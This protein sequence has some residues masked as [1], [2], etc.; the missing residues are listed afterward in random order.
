[1][2][3]YKLEF[4]LEHV[5][6][7]ID[8]SKNELSKLT[9][10][11]LN[12]DGMSG[13]KTRHLYNNL[14]SLDNANYLEIGTYK[15]SSFISSLY[16]NNIKSIAIDN[17]SEFN[18]PKLEFLNNIKRYSPDSEYHFIENDCFKISENDIKSIYESVDIY[19]YDG[20][21]DYESQKKAITYYYEYLSRYSI[22]IID[23]FRSDTE[24]WSNVKKGTF[25]GIKESGLKI[26]LHREI[27]SK[28]EDNG[29]RDYWNGCGIF[30]CEKI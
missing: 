19:L 24:N 14:C 20:S 9:P 2:N 7:S 16:K 11:I 30:V 17:W 18:G 23:D 6:K 15:G 10:E 4:L 29:R 21:H 3:K 27:D 12:M 8:N 28:Q 13:N 5:S 1:M 25:D 26:H 22:I